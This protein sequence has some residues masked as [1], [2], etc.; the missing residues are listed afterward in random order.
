M[1]NIC[2]TVWTLQKQ[3]SAN[4]YKKAIFDLVQ[5]R[6]LSSVDNLDEYTMPTDKPM[7]CYTNATAEKEKEKVNSTAEQQEA[8]EEHQMEKAMLREV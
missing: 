5:Q 8:W 2:F 4:R 7:H 6:Q 1:T 3:R